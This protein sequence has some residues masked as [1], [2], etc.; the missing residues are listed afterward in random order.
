MTEGLIFKYSFMACYMLW[1]W[2]SWKYKGRVHTATHK[3]YINM[4][5]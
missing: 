4:L 1:C 2:S 3:F 5:H